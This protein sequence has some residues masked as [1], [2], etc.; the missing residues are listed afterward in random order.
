LMRLPLLL[1]SSPLM[2]ARDRM[3]EVHCGNCGARFVAWY[4]TEE[5]ADTEVKDVEKCGLCG[6]DP[7]KKDNFQGLHFATGG[8]SDG[9]EHQAQLIEGAY[10]A[11]AGRPS[12]A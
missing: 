9:A 8:A 2:P 4:G 12:H 3:L 10:R 5:D 7:F 1:L 11:P 6:G